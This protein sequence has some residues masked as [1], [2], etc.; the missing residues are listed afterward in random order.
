MR[1]STHRLTLTLEAGPDPDP[2]LDND[3]LHKLCQ[4]KVIPGTCRASPT[5]SA[6]SAHATRSSAQLSNLRPKQIP[7]LSVCMTHATST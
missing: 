5:S 7:N 2:D 1:T 3:N 6:P 4:I